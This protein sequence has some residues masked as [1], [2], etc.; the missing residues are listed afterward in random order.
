MMTYPG[1]V[2]PFPAHK[3]RLKTRGEQAKQRVKVLLEGRRFRVALIIC[4]AIHLVGVLLY[5]V[6]VYL[7][8]REF[9]LMRQNRQV[10]EKL[11]YLEFQRTQLQSVQKIEGLYKGASGDKIPS[12]QA[13]VALQPDPSPVTLK[14]PPSKDL[15]THRNTQLSRAVALG[16]LQHQRLSA[17]Y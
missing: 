1:N 13:G 2:R 17:H 16:V 11:T 12:D 9:E 4:G 6:N 7:E 10:N 14:H 5:G 8:H 15:A 3:R